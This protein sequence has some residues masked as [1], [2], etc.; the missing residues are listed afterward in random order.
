M[1]HSTVGAIPT[2]TT[3]IPSRAAFIRAGGEYVKSCFFPPAASLQ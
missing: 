3:F 2:L 1:S